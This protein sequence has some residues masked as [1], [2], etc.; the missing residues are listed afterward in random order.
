[1]K[2]CLGED[3]TTSVMYAFSMLLVSLYLVG[4][5]CMVTCLQVTFSP[6]IGLEKV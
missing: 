4:W 5:Q 2:T 1:M 6:A 3:E